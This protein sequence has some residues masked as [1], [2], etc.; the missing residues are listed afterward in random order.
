MEIIQIFEENIA[1]SVQVGKSKTIWIVDAPQSIIK[2]Q[3]FAVQSN[4]DVVSINSL[5]V[6]FCGFLDQ[7]TIFLLASEND[8]IVKGNVPAGAGMQCT[9]G[10]STLRLLDHVMYEGGDNLNC[11]CYIP[12]MVHCLKNI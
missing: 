6:F 8:V 5:M 7:L 12:P 3:Q 2:L 1:E 10:D 11:K 4:G 9:F